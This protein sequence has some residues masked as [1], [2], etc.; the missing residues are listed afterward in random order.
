MSNVP[1]QYPLLDIVLYWPSRS[2][3][4]EG[5]RN[6]REER[7][8]EGEGGEKGECGVVA[9]ERSDAMHTALLTGNTPEH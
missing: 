3:L 9:E 5:E 4:K 1:A 2:I 6:R 7:G 8:G